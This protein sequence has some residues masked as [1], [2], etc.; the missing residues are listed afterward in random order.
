MIDPSEYSILIKKVKIDNET[1]FVAEVKELPDLR[2]Y[3]YSYHEAYELALEGI[4]ILSELAQDMHRGFPQPE[5]YQPL[6]S[7]VP[8]V[9]A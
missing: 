5:I 6:W 2:E 8:A 4:E 7:A 1:L 9:A 3:A